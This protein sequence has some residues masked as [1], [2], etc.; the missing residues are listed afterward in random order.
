MKQ[1]QE[2]AHWHKLNI[3]IKHDLLFTIC[4]FLLYFTIDWEKWCRSQSMSI[5]MDTLE[6]RRL[7]TMAKATG[8]YI[9]MLKTGR[10]NLSTI[11]NIQRMCVC[12]QLFDNFLQIFILAWMIN[13]YN[14][15]HL[16]IKEN[17]LVVDFQKCTL[18]CNIEKKFWIHT[19]HYTIL[20]GTWHCLIH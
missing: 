18:L 3:E 17:M 5:I 6:E 4:Y 16:L 2:S 20:Y 9:P 12:K 1:N 8:V 11:Y 13:Y 14:S 10:T 19:L 7:P 15:Q